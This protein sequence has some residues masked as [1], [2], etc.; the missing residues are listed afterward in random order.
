MYPLYLEEYREYGDRDIGELTKDY[1]QEVHN[2]GSNEVQPKRLSYPI[3]E[4]NNI[5]PC[6]STTIKLLDELEG[7]LGDILLPPRPNDPELASNIDEALPIRCELIRRIH[8]LNRVSGEIRERV[9]GL[10]E[11]LDL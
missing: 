8:E 6:Q 2:M 9:N 5:I 7:R 4:L 1:I 3:E 11:R 10:I